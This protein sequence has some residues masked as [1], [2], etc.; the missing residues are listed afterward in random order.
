MLIGISNLELS[1]KRMEINKLQNGTIVINDTYNANYDS[2]K[3]ALDYLKRIDG[4]RKIAILGDMLE[5]GEFSVSLHEKVGLEVSED[6]DILITVGEDAKNIAKKAMA[7]E[8]FEFNSNIEAITRIKD[9]I[10][11]NDA[12]LLKASNGM[13]FNEIASQIIE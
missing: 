3:A 7:K 10:R 8:V 13:H 9:I 12:I 6:I 4:R 5:L 11:E 2:M 1:K